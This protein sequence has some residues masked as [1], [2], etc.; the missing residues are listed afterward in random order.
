MK[1]KLLSN[2]GDLLEICG[3]I[4]FFYEAGHWGNEWKMMNA[5]G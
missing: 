5:T 3:T 1:V 2:F 4:V